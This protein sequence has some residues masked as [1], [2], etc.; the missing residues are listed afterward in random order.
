MSDVGRGNAEARQFVERQIDAIAARILADVADDIGELERGAE[1]FGVA[2]RC[3][4]AVA[5]NLCR[6]QADHTRHPVTIRLQRGEV[7]IAVVLQIHLHPV[8]DFVE[9][10]PR[11]IETAHHRDQGLCHRMLRR[12]GKSAGDLLAPPGELG[13]GEIGV[14]ALI[15][16]VVHLPTVGVEGGDR[17]AFFRRQEQEAVV[18]ARAA[19]RR[20]VLAILVGAHG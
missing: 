17:A 9:T 16:H 18:E 6:H 10:R 13:P 5:E 8:D 12:A 3:G 1:V 11:E 20:L 7:G 15:H 14:A 2:Q 4:I 19:L